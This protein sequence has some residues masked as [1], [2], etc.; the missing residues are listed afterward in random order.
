MSR[1]MISIALVVGLATASTA[2]TTQVYRPGP[3]VIGGQPLNAG[4]DCPDEVGLWNPGPAIQPY[5]GGRFVVNAYQHTFSATSECAQQSHQSLFFSPDGDGLPYFELVF[6]N[7]PDGNGC[8]VAYQ[9]GVDPF[10]GCDTAQILPTSGQYQLR[11]I[12]TGNK[13][14]EFSYRWRASSDLAWSLWT[15]VDEWDTGYNEVERIFVESSGYTTKNYEFPERRSTFTEINVRRKSTG[16]WADAAIICPNDVAGQ[17]SILMDNDP[18][19][20]FDRQFAV[21]AGQAKV[22]RGSGTC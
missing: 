20:K 14:W 6:M 17:I 3:Q 13:V 12:H 22:I 9:N 4:G 10:E 5:D 15:V 19:Y 1:L 18:E 2:S 11:G 21:Q 16:T 8:F 7:F